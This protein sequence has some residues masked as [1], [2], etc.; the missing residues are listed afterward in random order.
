[1]CS[2]ALR[3]KK[4]FLPGTDTAFRNV[5]WWARFLSETTLWESLV[6]TCPENNIIFSCFVIFWS[7]LIEAMIFVYPT[8]YP[9]FIFARVPWLGPYWNSSQ[10]LH[11]RRFF[12]LKL[13]DRVV[14]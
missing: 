2:E 12:L 1:M 10:C 5:E 9:S 8:D 4:N 11:T 6:N 14:I 13:W 3:K 7:D